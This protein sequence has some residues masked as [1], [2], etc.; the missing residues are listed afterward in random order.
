MASLFIKSD[1]AARLA[2]EVSALRGV[3]KTTAVIDA[4]R[5]QRDMLKPPAPTPDFPEWLAEFHR[6]HPLPPP[7]GLKADKA[8]F[9]WLSGEEDIDD[10]VS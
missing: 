6:Q 8:F 10:G 9:D 1:E 2:A 7:T 4:L 3:T 5:L